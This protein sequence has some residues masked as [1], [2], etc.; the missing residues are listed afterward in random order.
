MFRWYCDAARCYVYLSDVATPPLGSKEE[1]SPPLWN[2]AFR[3]S[4]WFTRGWTLQELLAPRLVEFFSRHW[5]RL[6]DKISLTQEIHG[7]TGIPLL[8]LEGAPL[9]QFSFDERLR[10]KGDR[11]TKRDEDAWYSLSG[12]FGVKIAPAYIEG[13][14]SAFRR[15][16]NEI[17][18]LEGCVQ[19]IRQTD[20]RDDKKR[21]E[22]TK[23]G[24]LA[25]SYRWVLD[26]TT[27]QQ[28]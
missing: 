2:L 21:I 19:D 1:V 28:W 6:G 11:A 23:G 18:K 8:A 3:Q 15:L 10:W 17:H 7:V 16:I 26:N 14:A 22:E 9:S 4:K 20:P 12:I 27:F 5:T 13:A 25:D 24:L